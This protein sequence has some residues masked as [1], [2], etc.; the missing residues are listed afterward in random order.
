[1]F[2]SEIDAV[3]DANRQI[4]GDMNYVLTSHAHQLPSLLNA[5]NAAGDVC[6]IGSELETAYERQK[7]ENY[8]FS[9]TASQPNFVRGGKDHFRD[10]YSCYFGPHH[11]MRQYVSNFRARPTG[12]MEDNEKIIP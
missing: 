2:F 6:V 7:V 8:M 1:M 12:K 9:V 10:G 11:I 4:A 5:Y 3:Q